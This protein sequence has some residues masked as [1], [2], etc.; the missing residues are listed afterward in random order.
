MKLATG[1]HSERL[2]EYVGIARWGTF[3]VP[4]LLF[5]T[6]GGDAEEIERFHVIDALGE[7]IGAGRIKVYSCDSVA[8]RTW[9]KE[10]FG[11][12]HRAWI[13]NQ[14]HEFV[15]RELVP[16]IREDCKM[17]DIEVIAAGS[18][19]GAFNAVA[20]TC[21]YPEIFRAALGVSGTYDPTRFL[22]EGEMPGDLYF[23]SPIHF[24]PGLRG[25]QLD[26]LRTRRILIASGQGRAE[27]LGESWKM[28]K[29]LGDAGVPNRVDP[30]GEEWHHDWPTWRRMFPLYL[31]ELTR[32]VTG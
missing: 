14:F 18:S 4:V 10:G 3:G 11:D 6:A 13:Q 12:R 29:A 26:R 15:A 2:G 32:P 19:I 22:T 28:A 5:P 9:L 8:G 23:S 27:D 21:R 30:W 20:V 16:A 24:L 1:W 31:D 25:P 17:P 7:L